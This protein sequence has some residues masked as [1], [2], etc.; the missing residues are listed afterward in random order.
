MARRWSGIEEVKETSYYTGRD[1]LCFPFY[2][3]YIII[4]V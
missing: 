1:S 4:L 3:D 2:T